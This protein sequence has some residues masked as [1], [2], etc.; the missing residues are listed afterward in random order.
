[1]FKKEK[2]TTVY[3]LIQ[4]LKA[5]NAFGID[6]YEAEIQIEREGYIRITDKK[7]SA[8]IY[9]GNKLFDDSI[10]IYTRK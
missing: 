8:H 5:L 1:M 10:H 7:K 2:K 3:E 6:G 9:V 4:Q